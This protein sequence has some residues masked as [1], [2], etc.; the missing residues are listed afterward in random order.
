MSY[1]DLYEWYEYYKAE[2]FMS[3]RIEVQLATISQLIANF[4]GSKLKHE[5]FMISRK[6]K[7]EK[8]LKEFEDDIKAKFLVFAKK[9]K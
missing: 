6:V 9:D 7:K 5:D 8:T 4:G 2:P 3:D 1:R